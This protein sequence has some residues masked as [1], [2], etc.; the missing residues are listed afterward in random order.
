M[1]I[2]QEITKKLPLKVSSRSKLLR[3][4]PADESVA[5]QTIL[6]AAIA[7]FDVW[8]PSELLDVTSSECM[9]AL[10]NGSLPA[11]FKA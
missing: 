6:E 9:E 10:T 7:I 1:V 11:K 8:F 2:N 4:S 3:Q 5:P